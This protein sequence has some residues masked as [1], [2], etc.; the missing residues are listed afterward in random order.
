MPY[1]GKDN[2]DIRNVVEE[3]RQEVARIE[4]AIAALTGLGSQP[5][6]RGRPPKVGKVEPRAGRNVAA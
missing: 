3:L 6:R 4:R 1:Y 2:M 5:E